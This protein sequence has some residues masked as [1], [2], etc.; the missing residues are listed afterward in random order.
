MAGR[1]VSSSGVRREE[2]PTGYFERFL[3]VSASVMD[4]CLGQ[5][6]VL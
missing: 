6:A 3:V 2:K 1:R 5:T 4:S